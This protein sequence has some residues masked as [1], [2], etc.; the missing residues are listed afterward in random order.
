M[1]WD[2]TSIC[3]IPA[4]DR[5]GSTMRQHWITLQEKNCV[6]MENSVVFIWHTVMGIRFQPHC[7]TDGYACFVLSVSNLI[8]FLQVKNQF[9]LHLQFI[10]TFLCSKCIC[11][12]LTIPLKWWKHCAWFSQIMSKMNSFNMGSFYICINAMLLSLPE[13]CL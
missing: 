9:C 13:N 1:Q 6:S 7:L 4:K 11:V 2:S 5:I 3:D 12:L 10:S 8:D